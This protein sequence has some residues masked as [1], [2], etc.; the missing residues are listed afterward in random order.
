MSASL[1]RFLRVTVSVVIAGVAQV[2]G[3]DPRYLVIAPVIS[4]IGKFI[5]DTYKLSWLPF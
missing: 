1:V 3:Q 5:R 4:G 2:Y